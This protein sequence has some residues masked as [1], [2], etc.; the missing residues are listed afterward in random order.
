MKD[1]PLAVGAGVVESDGWKENYTGV[2]V[3]VLRNRQNFLEVG[4]V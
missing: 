1:A 3:E 4:V 2:F